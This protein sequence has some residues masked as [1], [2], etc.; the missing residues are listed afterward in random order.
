MTT[1]QVT[2]IVFEAEELSHVFGETY[3]F[4][5]SHVFATGEH[6]SLTGFRVD[7]HN[8]FYYVILFTLPHWA[9]FFGFHEVTPNQWWITDICG[10]SL[11]LLIIDY[12]EL[13]GENTVGF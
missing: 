5:D 2:L 3:A 1:P 12:V 13:G 7:T 4:K 9:A 10:F 6:E 8:S 11:H